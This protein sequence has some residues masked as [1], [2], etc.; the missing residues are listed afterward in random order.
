MLLLLGSG[1]FTAEPIRKPLSI[2]LFMSIYPW[3]IRSVCVYIYIYTHIYNFPFILL[4]N[5]NYY[6]MGIIDDT[7]SC[8][9]D[10]RN[11]LNGSM[12]VFSS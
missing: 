7:V 2:Y 1:F 9:F 4:I 10:S 3:N 6:I 12:L 8:C 11:Y 5:L